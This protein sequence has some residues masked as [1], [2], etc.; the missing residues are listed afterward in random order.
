MAECG[1]APSIEDFTKKNG[2]IRYTAYNKAY[3]RW[4]LCMNPEVARAR[5]EGVGAGLDAA[6]EFASGVFDTWAATQ[7][8]PIPGGGSTGRSDEPMYFGGPDSEDK[9]DTGL[10]QDLD[11]LEDVPTWVVPAVAGLALFTFLRR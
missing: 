2:N 1:P 10:F 11:L 5:A 4:L 6:G 9:P 7:M 8:P 3:K